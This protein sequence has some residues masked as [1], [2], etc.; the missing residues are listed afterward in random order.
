MVQSKWGG[1]ETDDNTRE[2]S[3]DSCHRGK[4]LETRNVHLSKTV[5]GNSSQH[6]LNCWMDKSSNSHY[7]EYS[8]WSSTPRDQT[9]QLK[10]KEEI[11]DY[12]DRCS[13]AKST[14]LNVGDK[15]LIKQPKQDKMSKPFK[16]QPLEITRQERKHDDSLKS[17]THCDQKCIILQYFATEHLKDYMTW[18]IFGLIA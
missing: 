12:A 6:L 5:Q 1:R 16:P 13:H 8:W 18:T 9:N 11:Q 4:E 15:V 17:W 2:S 14:D 3:Q 7:L 10:I